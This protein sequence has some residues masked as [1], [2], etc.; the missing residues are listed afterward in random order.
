MEKKVSFPKFHHQQ[1]FLGTVN[2]LK[3]TK[4]FDFFKFYINLLLE[5]QIDILFYKNMFSFY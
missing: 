1:F 3:P 5:I 2:F 4:M